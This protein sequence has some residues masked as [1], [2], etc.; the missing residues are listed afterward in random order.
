MFLK[1]FV[2]ARAFQP[3]VD[4]SHEVENTKSLERTLKAF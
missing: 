2:A 4:P 1:L 3:R